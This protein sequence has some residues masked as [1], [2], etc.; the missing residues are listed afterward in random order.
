MASGIALFAVISFLLMAKYCNLFFAPWLLQDT[1]L[2]LFLALSRLNSDHFSRAFGASV[3]WLG[4]GNMT[5]RWCPRANVNFTWVLLQQTSCHL[6]VL[7]ILIWFLLQLTGL[8]LI[9]NLQNILI[10]F[11]RSQ[12]CPCCRHQSFYREAYSISA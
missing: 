8:L 5:Q 1:L 2:N 12:R 7:W 10:I 6:T 11:I 9:F 3:H 4:G